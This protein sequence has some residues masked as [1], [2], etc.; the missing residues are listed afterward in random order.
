M[1]KYRKYKI[2]VSNETMND[3]CNKK[4]EFELLPQQ[5]F[6]AEYLFDNQHINGLLIFHQIGSGKTCTAINIAEKFKNILKIVIVL[7]ASLIGNFRNEIRS[8]C[9]SILNNNI[10]ISKLNNEK[11]K[12]LLPNNKEYIQIINESNNLI[13]KIYNIYSYHKFIELINTPINTLGIPFDLNN[14]LL[15]IDEIQNMISLSGVFYNSLKYCINKTNKLL[16]IILLTGTPMMDNPNEIGLL[17]NLFRPKIMFP[18]GDDFNKY[19]KIKNN[20]LEKIDEFKYMCRGLVSY[21]RGDLPISYPDMN[22][23]VLRCIMSDF[24]FES[25]KIAIRK[26]KKQKKNFFLDADNPIKLSANFFIGPRIISNITFPNQ[27]TGGK[28][29]ESIDI[30]LNNMRKYSIKFHIIYNKIKESNGPIFIYSQFLDVG[31]LKSLIKYFEFHG[32]TKYNMDLIS[33]TKKNYAIWSGSES[34]LK[35]EN[36]KSVFN[37]YENNDGSLIKILFG[38]PAAKEGISLLRVE[39]VHI[40]EPYWNMSRIKQ[41]IGRAVRYC[42]HKDMPED[43]RKVDVFIYLACYHT[44]KTIDE[45][46]WSMAKKK[47]AVIDIFEHALKEVAI[48]CNLFYNRNYYSTDKKKII[49][50][51]YS[52]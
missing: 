24:Q 45:Y 36:I 52:L 14:T 44:T 39:Q 35:R 7:P 5:K 47:G 13:D 30:A 6:I 29:Y 8:D 41:I 50:S 40:V 32:Y 46:I 25:Y 22:L 42:S 2:P 21:Y 4:K 49:C 15:I 9:T 3:I 23:Q 28:G 38:S 12:K 37:S 11:L 26:E 34:L 18:V 1:N 10:Y 16:K 51:N 48:D 17:F 33:N 31:G 43:K 19:F 20:E 27:K